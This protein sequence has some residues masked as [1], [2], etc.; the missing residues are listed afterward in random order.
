MKLAIT[1]PTYQRDDGKTPEFLIR[2]LTSVKNQTHQDFKIFLIGDKYENN[3]EFEELANSVILDQS[4]IHYVNLEH[5]VERERY[6][7]VANT[8]LNKVN[9]PLWCSGGTNARNTGIEL[10]LKEGYTY[11]C[12][13]DHDDYWDNIHLETLNIICELNKYLVVAT[14]STFSHGSILPKNQNEGEFF[15]PACNIVHSSTCIDFSKTS[16]RYRD[17]L[18][19]IGKEDAGDADMWKQLATFM[20]ANNMIGWMIDK[21]TCHYGC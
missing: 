17:C 3:K 9:K 12:A 2:A 21:V 11:C 8:N 1:I 4:K 19:E 15:P 18:H 10:A 16:I 13:L 5:A 20:T 7:C 14:K 6:N